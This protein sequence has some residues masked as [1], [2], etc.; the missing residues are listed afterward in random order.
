MSDKPEDVDERREAQPENAPVPE[1]QPEPED[2]PE[3]TV[4]PE[5]STLEP[6]DELSGELEAP[7]SLYS[8]LEGSSAPAEKLDVPLQSSPASNFEP[9]RPEE[10]KKPSNR[11]AIILVAVIFLIFSFYI[12]ATVLRPNAQTN[13]VEVNG[14]QIAF[15]SLISDCKAVPITPDSSSIR[16][17]VLKADKVIIAFDPN[18]DARYALGVTEAYKVLAFLKVNAVYAYSAPCNITVQKDIESCIPGVPVLS[19]SNGTS[20]IPVVSLEMQNATFVRSNAP[21]QI[22]VSGA[23]PSAYDSAVCAF[24]LS[25]LGVS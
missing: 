25:V 13:V 7:A 19:A 16:D 8:R 9:F 18:K 23:S 4:E 21:G 14:Q 22:I 12:Y 24:D 17:V 2:G 3:S 1:A 5:D 20:R 6:E 11:G 15:R 10:E